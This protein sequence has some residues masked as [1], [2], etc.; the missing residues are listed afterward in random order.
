MPQP[1]GAAASECVLLLNRAAQAD[2]VFR[3]IGTRNA[4]PAAVTSPL[5]AM[6]STVGSGVTVPAYVCVSVMALLLVV[7][8]SSLP[9]PWPQVCGIFNTPRW[10]RLAILSL[11]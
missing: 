5:K 9:E 11:W 6:S 2:D 1:F 10:E 3:G 4:S 8:L 7:Q